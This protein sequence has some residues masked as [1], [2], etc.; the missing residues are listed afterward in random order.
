MKK[1]GGNN[2][3]DLNDEYYNEIMENFPI[4]DSSGNIDE[5][6]LLDFESIERETYET[7]KDKDKSQLL[8][9]IAELE[10]IIADDNMIMDQMNYR[11]EELKMEMQLIKHPAHKGNIDVQRICEMYESGCS[12]S[13]IAKQLNC[14]RG[15]VKSRLIKKGLIK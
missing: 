5:F 3:G 14:S 15:T 7:Y 13:H 9:K 12:Q 8:S 11:I 6:Y 1:L 10:S 2:V 4:D